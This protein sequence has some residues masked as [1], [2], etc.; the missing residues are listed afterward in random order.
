MEK[1]LKNLSQAYRSAQKKL[2]HGTY[3]DFED[4]AIGTTDLEEEQE[5]HHVDLHTLS[6]TPDTHYSAYTTCAMEY[7]QQL[8][9]IQSIRTSSSLPHSERPLQQ[10]LGM[11]H[12]VNHLRLPTPYIE[13]IKYS[14]T[15]EHPK[16]HSE[17][18][19]PGSASLTYTN[20]A[21]S[22]DQARVTQKKVA[23]FNRVRDSIERL[24]KTEDVEVTSPNNLFAGDVLGQHQATRTQ[25]SVC[26]GAESMPNTDKRGLQSQ[27]SD[28]YPR[29]QSNN[30]SLA[31]I[32]P[33]SESA[34]AASTPPGNER[35][36]ELKQTARGPDL[37]H[38]ES[39]TACKE[40]VLDRLMLHFH[41]VFTTRGSEIHNRGASSETSS[42]P[43]YSSDKPQGDS[44]SRTVKRGLDALRADDEQDYGNDDN[45][46]DDDDGSRKRRRKSERSV[47][48]N[49]AS[50]K[51]FACPYFKHNPFKDRASRACSGPGFLTIAKVKYDLQSHIGLNSL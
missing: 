17:V 3:H 46:D 30:G 51:R 48:S 1:G 10:S 21:R 28:S 33:S 27:Y 14:D 38:Q 4:S 5:D 32:K 34:V 36:S 11:V 31:A 2:Q 9:N 41:D 6:A 7:R 12:S 19:V 49:I 40:E 15:V 44:K 39:T 24:I 26:S 35:L 22:G 13:P 29:F 42:S 37:L 18:T 50:H 8:P 23:N 47:K 16:S 20:P 43:K 45:N 25:N